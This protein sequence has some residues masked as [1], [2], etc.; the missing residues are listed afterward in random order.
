MDAREELVRYY[1]LLREHGLNDS[2]SGNASVRD[3][4]TVW[5]TPTGCCADTVVPDDLMAVSNS[6]EVERHATGDGLTTIR[7]ADTMR[8]STYLVA[9]VEWTCLRALAP[10]LQPGQ[11][12][13]GTR[14]ELSHDAATP[15]SRPAT[16]GTPLAAASSM[17]RPYASRTA[18]QTNTSAAA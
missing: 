2:H 8:M 18:G 1:R 14:V 12:T 16:T 17:A 7:F 6:A 11:R 5:V 3:G 10:Y 9:F 4:D 15:P 13:L